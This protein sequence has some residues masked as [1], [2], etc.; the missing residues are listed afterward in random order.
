ML[1]YFEVVDFDL[2]LAEKNLKE[3]SFPDR[4]YDGIGED[5]ASWCPSPR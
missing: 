1:E 5:G 3:N 4:E 2:E